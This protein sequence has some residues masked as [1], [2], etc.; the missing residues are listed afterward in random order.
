MKDVESHVSKS[1][2]G[3][4]GF[5]GRETPGMKE[6]ESHVSKSRHGA[7]GFGGRE[8]PGMKEVESHVSKSRHGAA[9]FGGR[10]NPRDEGCGI[11]CLKNRDMGQPALV[12]RKEL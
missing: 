5:G 2:H 1:R 3:A 8:T 12:T 11:P 10:E 6:V 7:A 4:A 9:G